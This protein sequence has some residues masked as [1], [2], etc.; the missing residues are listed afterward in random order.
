[1]SK[2]SIRERLDY[3]EICNVAIEETTRTNPSDTMNIK[4]YEQLRSLIVKDL[5][6]DPAFINFSYG[7]AG[8]AKANGNTENSVA[9]IFNNYDKM[10]EE[11]KEL[12]EYIDY[13][14]DPANRNNSDYNPVFDRHMPGR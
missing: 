3:V 8:D 1:M 6:K 2:P 7:L 10:T 5:T 4:R 14:S 13:N 11:Q 12:E 9:I